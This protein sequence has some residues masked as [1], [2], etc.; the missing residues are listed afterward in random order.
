M[1]N[2][3]RRKFIRKVVERWVI[4][5]VSLRLR[6]KKLWLMTKISLETKCFERHEYGG[7]FSGTMSF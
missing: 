4:V 3:Q 7:R 6:R 1:S 2:L 5:G